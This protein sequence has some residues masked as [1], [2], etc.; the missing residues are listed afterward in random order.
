MYNQRG[1]AVADMVQTMLLE[2]Q[3]FLLSGTPH[4]AGRV[5]KALRFIIQE[6]ETAALAFEAAAN[7]KGDA[8]GK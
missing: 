5:A 3:A 4:D 7:T 1:R 2:K 6:A 8:D